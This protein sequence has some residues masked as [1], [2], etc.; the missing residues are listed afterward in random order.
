MKKRSVITMLLLVSILAVCLALAACDGLSSSNKKEVYDLGDSRRIGIMPTAYQPLYDGLP[1]TPSF[2]I[3]DGYDIIDTYDP[4][5]QHPDLR[6]EY[7]DNVNVGTAKAV[8]TAVE[9]SSRYKGSRT[10][11]FQ[12]LPVTSTV[13]AADIN[14]LKEL[15][16]GN[17]T[18]VLLSAAI[19]VPEGEVLT[20]PENVTLDLGS[21]A[22]TNNGTFVNCGTILVSPVAGGLPTVCNNGEFCNNGTINLGN[23]AAFFNNGTFVNATNASVRAGNTSGFYTQTDVENS[24][25]IERYFRRYDLDE[26]EVSLSFSE[27]VYNGY[28][29]RPSV[30]IVKDNL[31]APD[32]A[33]YT[34]TYADNLNAGTASVTVEATEYSKTLTGSVTLRFEILRAE[35]T[36]TNSTD[37]YSALENSN[38]SKIIF[39]TIAEVRLSQ[40][41]TVPEDTSVVI[42]ASNLTTD[43]TVTNNG[44]LAIN[45]TWTCKG[46]L[47]NNGTLTARCPNV[48]FND[49]VHNYGTLTLCASVQNN[50]V[51][52]NAGTLSTEEEFV[53]NAFLN[54]MGEFVN[55]GTFFQA[56]EA[57]ISASAPLINNG[58]VYADEQLDVFQGGVFVVRELLGADNVTLSDTTF[59]YDGYP[60]F[61]TPS[62]GK[63]NVD[64]SSYTLSYRYVGSEESGIRP[65][66]AGVVEVFV[67]FLPTSTT[68]YGGY[69]LQYEILPGSTS[70]NGFAELQSALSDN[71]Y[72]AVT[73]NGNVN[74]SSPITV[75]SSC[76]LTVAEGVDAIN[77]SEITVNGTLIVNG[78]F[79]EKEG[80]SLVFGTG[81]IF[82]NNGLAY[83]NETAPAPLA[84]TGTNFVR[85]SLKTAVAHDFPESAKYGTDT[86][87]DVVLY[88]GD[89][90]LEKGV[91]Y[92]TS[93]LNCSNVTKKGE[94]AQ[95]VSKATTFSEKYYGTHTAKYT[96]LAGEISVATFDELYAAL[97]DI[98]YDNVCNYGTITLTANVSKA[99]D[100]YQSLYV[101]VAENTTL[102]LGN[103]NLSLRSS[104]TGRIF[105]VNNGT[106]EIYKKNNF[107]NS[108]SYSGSGKVVAY[109]DNAR[110]AYALAWCAHVIKLSAD[111]TDYLYISSSLFDSVTVDL[112]GHTL[113][114]L[115]VSVGEYERTQHVYVT[116]SAS[117]GVLGEKDSTAAGLKLSS[118]SGVQEV[119]LSNITVYGISCKDSSFE[120]I[121]SV[122]YSSCTV[123]EN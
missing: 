4:A 43:G 66:N 119:K 72:N 48:A 14:A 94:F 26:Y 30:S 70:A 54:N 64:R 86:T 5:I 71:N 83:F 59:V 105:L 122:D 32:Y 88:F 84:G 77:F 56:A 65:V 90:M 82:E 38:Y 41:F 29:Q 40:N 55:A 28:E 73:L 35:K 33:D 100:S 87:P 79:A 74:V 78:R 58:T 76:T 50:L 97:N 106:I 75:R 53:N 115:T 85:S 93:Y 52:L 99:H 49:T 47:T 112:N 2:T 111:I 121:L 21:Y 45:E 107:A 67:S 36:V 37:F 12:I 11:E 57:E 117:G 103:H 96:V 34:L 61:A 69:T 118:L 9:G 7:S 44:S 101:T 42:S 23:D 39:D 18:S 6:V 60:H 15:L 95:A 13:V 89:T 102:V 16:D 8:F 1:K 51:L 24:D 27:T 104:S 91:D 31:P 123:I 19:E 63:E 109:A 62:F 110:D 120:Q 10:V 20:V 46:A 22:L 114:S 17:R 3:T 81:G 68:Y 92:T 98:A 108:A 25:K 80:S 113:T 116:S